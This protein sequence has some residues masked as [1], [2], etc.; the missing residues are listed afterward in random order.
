[1]LLNLKVAP[2][3]NI[4]T[5]LYELPSRL[6]AAT[7]ANACRADLGLKAISAHKLNS[8]QIASKMNYSKQGDVE[9]RIDELRGQ[10]NEEN[11]AVIN[12]QINRLIESVQLMIQSV[13]WQPL[14][15]C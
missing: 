6:K 3:I 9:V 1:L 2:L 10:L 15:I 8:I 5:Y 11:Q 7:S 12:P 4:L 13:Y 14:F